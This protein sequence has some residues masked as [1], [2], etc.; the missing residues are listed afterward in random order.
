M[1]FDVAPVIDQ[2]VKIDLDD[3]NNDALV[4]TMPNSLNSILSGATNGIQKYTIE[5]GDLHEAEQLDLCCYLNQLSSDRIQVHCGGQGW[6]RNTD[7][8]VLHSKEPN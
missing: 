3:A 1:L 4:F 8:L 5:F 6:I 7:L 2:E